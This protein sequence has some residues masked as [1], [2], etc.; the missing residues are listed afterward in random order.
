MGLGYW[1]PLAG[2]VTARVMRAE[3]DAAA[4]VAEERMRYREALYRTA[5]KPRSR[6]TKKCPGC[7]SHTFAMTRVGRVCSYCRTPEGDDA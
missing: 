1:D 3:M 2:V 5:A 6:K 7:G 4:R